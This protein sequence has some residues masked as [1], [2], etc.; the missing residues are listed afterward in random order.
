M[1]SEQLSPALAPFFVDDASFDAL[2]PGDIRAVSARFWTP[3]PIAKRAAELLV[4][5]GARTV[6]DVGSGA[7]KFC[8]VLGAHYPAARIVGVEYRAGLV[9]IARAARDR[10]GL[11]NVS[12]VHDDVTGLPW[13]AFDGFYFYNSFAENLFD[14]RDR[15]DDQAE[16]SMHRFSRDI[17]RSHA[18]LREARAGALVATFYGSSTRVPATFDLVEQEPAGEGWLRLWA[19]TDRADDGSYFVEDG[20]E[21]VRHDP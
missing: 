3:L 4:E 8:L 14:P 18:L 1:P 13:E 10:L 11:G 21:N 15:L 2:Y 17:Q 6:L 16:L 7:G 5:N 9:P 20:G 19:K 12:F